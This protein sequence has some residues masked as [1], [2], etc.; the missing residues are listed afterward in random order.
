MQNRL[1]ARRGLIN[2]T[3]ENGLETRNQNSA[4]NSQNLHFKRAKWTKITP[5]R[6]AFILCNMCKTATDNIYTKK[7]P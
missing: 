2:S 4:F 6:K 1:V 5:T 3:M 7:P